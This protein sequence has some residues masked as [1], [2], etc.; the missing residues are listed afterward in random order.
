MVKPGRHHVKFKAEKPVSKRVEV[1][2][3]RQ[4][5]SV[6]KFPAHKKVKQKANVDFMARN[7]K[8]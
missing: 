1:E 6:A 5:G 4:D 8:K 7:K 3:E 2:F